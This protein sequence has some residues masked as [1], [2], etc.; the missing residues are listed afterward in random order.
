MAGRSSVDAAAIPP[1]LRETLDQ[2]IMLR[3]GGSPGIDR[4]GCMNLSL[5]RL[6]L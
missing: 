3:N 2:L 5:V 1:E 4:Y 6:D